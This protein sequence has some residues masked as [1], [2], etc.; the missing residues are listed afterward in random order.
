MQVLLVII[1]LTTVS[2]VSDQHLY[3][4]AW[5]VPSRKDGDSSFGNCNVLLYIIAK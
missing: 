4:P 3:P 2:V 5:T 1:C